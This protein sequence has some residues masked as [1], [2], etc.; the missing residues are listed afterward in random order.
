MALKHHFRY[1]DD[2]R[3]MPMA[4]WVHVEQDGNPWWESTHYS[5]PAP[6]HLSGRGYP[7]LNIEVRDETLCFSSAAQLHAFIETLTRTPLPSTMRLSAQ[8]GERHGPNT[9][10][11]SRLPAWMKTAKFRERMLPRLRQL[12]QSLQEDAAQT[13]WQ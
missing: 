4:F 5:P 12:A 13:G 3:Y 9:H 7:I 6:R 11:L 8:R 2:W 1:D 10:W